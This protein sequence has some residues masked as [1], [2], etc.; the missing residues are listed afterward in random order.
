MKPKQPAGLP[1]TLDKFM[2]VTFFGALISIC[3]P[4]LAKS[5]STYESPG[6]SGAFFTGNEINS[7]CTSKPMAS[8][9]AAGLW[10]FS[11]RTVL[12]LQG[13]VP[14]TQTRDARVDMAFDQLGRF[15]EPNG[16]TIEQVTDIFCGYLKSFPE[17]RH[18][19]AAILFS[20][21]MRKAWPC[22]KP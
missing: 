6:P 17:S 4:H 2:I 22:A 21:A 3:A 5:A 8:A 12:N 7:W 19:P 9:Y 10:D 16:V 13:F 15:C 11:A 14:L 18:K 1:M 20:E